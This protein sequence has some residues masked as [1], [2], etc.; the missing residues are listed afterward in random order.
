MWVMRNLDDIWEGVFRTMLNAHLKIVRLFHKFVLT[1]FKYFLT[2]ESTAPTTD[3]TMS[4]SWFRNKLPRQDP[5]S[6]AFSISNPTP[7]VE[8]RHP[9]PS[10]QLPGSLPPDLPSDAFNEQEKQLKMNY[11]LPADYIKWLARGE[12]LVN[13]ITQEA[14]LPSKLPTRFNSI[15]KCVNSF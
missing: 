3:L 15:D 12:A 5:T 6:Q 1:T 8:T 11:H 14:K 13:K 9:R 4:V 10:H 7:G 2:T